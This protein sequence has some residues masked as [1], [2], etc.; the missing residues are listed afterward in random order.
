MAP[1]MALCPDWTES[2]ASDRE[3]DCSVIDVLNEGN[4][5]RAIWATLNRCAIKKLVRK[6]C[7]ARNAAFG[8]T[9][10]PGS[11]VTGPPALPVLRGTRHRVSVGV[12]RQDAT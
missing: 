10:S 7:R 1:Y 3:L 9:D 6:L 12:H 4:P 2:S 5:H 8:A 11:N